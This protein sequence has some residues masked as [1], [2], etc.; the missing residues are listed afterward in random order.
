MPLGD[1]LFVANFTADARVELS[2]HFADAVSNVRLNNRDVSNDLLVRCAPGANT[3]HFKCEVEQQPFAWLTG[4]F[5]IQSLTQFM[6]GPG[7]TVATKGPLTLR[8][9]AGFRPDDLI[10]SG[11]P[12]C[13]NPITVVG[14]IDLPATLS[15]L[16]LLDV[17]ADCV[18]VFVDDLEIGWCW[19]PNWRVQPP[20]PLCAGRHHIR[21]DLVPSTF[22]FYGPHHHIDGDPHVVSPA[23]YQYIRNFADRVDA[24]TCT[25]SEWWHFK[26]F[27]FSGRIA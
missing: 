2:L 18:R 5:L 11:F 15:D 8:P 3:V 24:P 12:F 27:G 19:G 16:S 20:K 22:N 26:C 6:P 21:L 10:A 4:L 25:R 1:R 14:E 17:H 7:A 23:Q 13:R 9:P